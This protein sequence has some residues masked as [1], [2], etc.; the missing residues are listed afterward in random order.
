MSI[1]FLFFLIMALACSLAQAQTDLAKIAAALP[2]L[3]VM[4]PTGLPIRV[5]QED[6]NGA[7]NQIKADPAWKRWS[8]S[9]RKSVDQWIATV[10]DQPDWVGGYMHALLDPVTQNPLRWSINLPMPVGTN[11]IAR[12]SREGWVAWLRN[13]NFR[14]IQE[15]ARLYRLT[16]EQ[17]YGEW[18]AGQIDFYANNYAA[19]PLRDIAGQSRMMGQGLDEA[20][21]CVP[22]L[23][24]VRLLSDF[25][26]EARISNWRDKLFLPIAHQLLV[27]RHRDNIRLWQVVAVTLI[28][29]QFNDQA[30]VKAGLDGP[31]GVRFMLK[32]GVTTDYFWYEGSLGYQTYVL[33]ALSPLFTHASLLGRAQELYPEM[34]TA[35]NLMLAPLQ[36]RFEDGMLPTPGDSM[37]RIKAL[38][39]GYYIEM[40]RTLPNRIS[41]IEASRKKTWETLIDPVKFESTTPTQLPMVKTKNFDSIR[42]AILK[43]GGWQVFIR[44]G[45]LVLNHSQQ[46]ALTTEIYFEDTPVSVS[47]GTVAYGSPLHKEY[48]HRAISHNATLVGGEGQSGFDPGIVDSFTVDPPAINAR[49]PKLT[50]DASATRMVDIRD[51]ELFDRLSLKLNATAAGN[52][53][54]G[55]LFHTDCALNAATPG[56]T[57]S[58]PSGTG[59]RFWENVTL[60]SGI[61][62]WRGKLRCNKL[63]FDASF[64]LNTQGSLYAGKTPTKPLPEKRESLY[65]EVI[66]RE[67]TLEMRLKPVR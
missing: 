55:F 12:K 51:G 26:D 43:E 8:D 16:G 25:A 59:F 53:R 66:G 30:L 50:K 52:Q 7:R 21:A 36:F 4:Q 1:R 35:Q 5:A 44:Y 33:R 61:K 48:F 34:L 63:E 15:A 62:E 56:A 37:A 24:A 31:A 14:K 3:K 10:K 28:G 19:W 58:P 65:F 17:K 47:P 6:W 20:T 38:D 64:S 2:E 54:L 9:Q 67:A 27:S 39:L 22:L 23:D 29:F 45:Q 40:Y 49:Q 11:E 32:K 41:L 13:A 46:D 57:A 42:M 18:A 60:N